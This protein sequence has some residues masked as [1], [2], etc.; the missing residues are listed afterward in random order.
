MIRPFL[1]F[2][3]VVLLATACQSGAPW[4]RTETLFTQLSGG[5]FTLHRDIIIPAGRVRVIFQGGV[6]DLG[7][8]EYYPRCELEVRLILDTPQ[9]VP[10]G[11]YRIGKVI[12][13]QRLV[14]RPAA[15]IRLA[16]AGDAVLLADDTS[17]E[18]SMYTYRM[19]LLDG[20]QVDAATLTC[21]GQYDY[22]FKTRYPTLQEMQDALGAYA[23]LSLN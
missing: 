7:A 23:T 3:A 13:M 15:G 9:T 18:W 16:A 5:R 14:N 21:G 4:H 12:G 2:A 8:S 22:P 19:Q 17:S 20:Q 11:T 6:A 10:A 1:V